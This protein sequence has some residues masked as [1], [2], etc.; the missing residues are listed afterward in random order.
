MN[1]IKGRQIILKPEWLE[2]GE[3]NF[4]LIATTEDLGGRLHAVW[5]LGW[6]INP[7]CVIKTEWIKEII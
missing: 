6:A 2:D 3:E 7:T 5:N 4:E 1:M